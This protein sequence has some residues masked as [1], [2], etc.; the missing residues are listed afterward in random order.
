M[1]GLTD[2]IASPVVFCLPPLIIFFK[3]LYPNPTN[4]DKY[5]YVDKQNNCFQYE[6]DETQIDVA[7]RVRPTAD[8]TAIL[9]KGKR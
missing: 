8:R 3:K 6:L 4:V 2:L 9:K 1:A 7:D 5:T